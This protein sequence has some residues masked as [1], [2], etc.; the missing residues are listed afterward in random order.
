MQVLG[1]DLVLVAGQQDRM[2]RG[3]DTWANPVSYDKLAVRY[4]RWRNAVGGGDDAAE[5]GA[6]EVLAM[7]SGELFS[8]ED[9]DVVCEEDVF[10]DTQARPPRP[11]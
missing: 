6:R 10:A 5:A 9:E 7:S 1:E 11:A 8:L 3:A 4:R 2:M